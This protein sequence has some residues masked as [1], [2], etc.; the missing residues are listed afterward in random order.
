MPQFKGQKGSDSWDPNR[1][2]LFKKQSQ[3]SQTVSLGS[4]PHFLICK[5]HLPQACCQDFG[6]AP[7]E[8]LAQSLA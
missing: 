3:G 5:V 1:S 2:F 7:V 4:E 6:R 8:A